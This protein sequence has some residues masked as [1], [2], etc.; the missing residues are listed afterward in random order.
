MQRAEDL[1]GDLVAGV[2][3]VFE[4]TG[5]AVDVNVVVQQIV[6][7]TSAFERVFCAAVK[8]VE[9]P[10]VLWDE[11]KSGKHRLVEP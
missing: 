11:A 1:M 2:L 8:K 7:Q 4:M 5:L 9:E 6:E 10:F 3:D